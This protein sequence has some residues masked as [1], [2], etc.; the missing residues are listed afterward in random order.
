MWTV[1]TCYGVVSWKAMN[2]CFCSDAKIA[3][4][5][6]IILFLIMLNFKEWFYFENY[7]TK[8]FYFSS[9][10]TGWENLIN[11]GPDFIFQIVGYASN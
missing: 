6:L 7:N 11:S 9:K 4:E 10:E 8:H 3:N 1:V 5:I 2:T